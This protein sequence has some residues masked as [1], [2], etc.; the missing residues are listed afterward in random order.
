MK[1][2]DFEIYPKDDGK[3]HYPGVRGWALDI[4]KFR[5]KSLI[6]VECDEPI[7]R[8]WPSILFQIG[9]TDL[10]Y[11]L[12]WSDSI[13]Q[14]QSGL[15]L[16]WLCKEWYSEDG[17]LNLTISW[18]ENDP[19]SLSLTTGL[20]KTFT[21]INVIMWTRTTLGG[22]YCRRRFRNVFYPDT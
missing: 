20:K 3:G 12:A 4:I 10:F 15:T 21:A 2:I 19:W 7:Y 14:S 13:S 9:P 18:D 1:L 5:R 6:E 17:K 16:W 22:E 8:S 11:Y